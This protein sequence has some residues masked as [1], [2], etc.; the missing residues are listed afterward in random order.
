MR[1]NRYFELLALAVMLQAQTYVAKSDSELDRTTI[2]QVAFSGEIV[3]DT[4]A[5]RGADKP[6]KDKFL[7]RAYSWSD[8]SVEDADCGKSFCTSKK[9]VLLV[10]EPDEFPDIRVFVSKAACKWSFLGWKKFPNFTESSERIGLSFDT[11]CG[12]SK[13]KVVEIWL[14]MASS[15]LEMH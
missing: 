14:D 2:T 12:S 6:S 9:L 4:I 13:Q 11:A 1:M 8:P 15:R 10:A 5:A 3:V 7:L